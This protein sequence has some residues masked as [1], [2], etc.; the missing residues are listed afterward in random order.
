MGRL[1]KR[2]VGELFITKASFGSRCL[3][4]GNI[5]INM[6]QFDCENL[7]SEWDSNEDVRARLRDGLTLVMSRDRAKESSI[8]QCTS[9]MDVLPPMLHRLYACGLKMPEINKV[10]EQCENVYALASK[11]ADEECIEDDAWELRKM[12]RFIKRKANRQEVSLELGL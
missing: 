2:C 3:E 4:K 7:S 5:S 1:G 8:N 9:N 6:M 12:L 10:K 11:A